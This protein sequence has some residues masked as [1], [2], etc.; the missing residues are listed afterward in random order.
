MKLC[1]VNDVVQKQEV[2]NLERHASLNDKS[3]NTYQ[4]CPNI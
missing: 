2:E 1:A 3:E 4:S